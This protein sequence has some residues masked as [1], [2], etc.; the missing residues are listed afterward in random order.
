M[1]NTWL[2]TWLIYTKNLQSPWA[3]T[4]RTGSVH[5]VIHSCQFASDLPRFH[6]PK[7]MSKIPMVWKT[8]KLEYVVA[9]HTASQ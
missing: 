2:I 9:G 5:E 8:W 4:S 6:H 7:V 3:V 1:A